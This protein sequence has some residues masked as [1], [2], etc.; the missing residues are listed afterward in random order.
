MTTPVSFSIRMAMGV[1]TWLGLALLLAG[2]QPAAAQGVRHGPAK[3][4]IR[5]SRPRDRDSV[6]DK[7]HN[8]RGRRS[9]HPDQ[10]AP[11]RD[12]DWIR[13]WQTEDRDG[14]GIRNL[15]DEFPTDPNRGW[16]NRIRIWKRSLSENPWDGNWNGT[17][18]ARERSGNN[19]SRRR[20]PHGRRR[21]P[22]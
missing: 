14:D 19:G 1:S 18:D 10:A 21:H 13:K 16:Q 22:E 12:R 20:Q 3:G 5:H 17:Y 6:R 2:P 7:R 11:D 8:R 9:N 15:Q 4:S